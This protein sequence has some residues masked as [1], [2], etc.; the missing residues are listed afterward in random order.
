MNAKKFA[1]GVDIGGTRTKV[2]LVDLASGQIVDILINPTVTDDRGRFIASLQDAFAGIVA[3]CQENG[4]EISG[5]GVGV[6]GYVNIDSGIVDTTFGFLPFMEDF[7][8]KAIVEDRLGIACRVDNDARLNALG[9]YYWGQ[10]KGAARLLAITLGTGVGVGLIH[11]G[12]FLNKHPQEH[13][14][15]HIKISDSGATCYCGQKGC[16]E[17]RISAAALLASYREH[18]G[19]AGSA[20]ANETETVRAVFQAAEACEPVA[21]VVIGR[22]LADLITAI[23]SYI[24]VFAPDIIV[25]GGG[26]SKNLAPRLREIERRIDARP[27]SSYHNSLYISALQEEAGVL[28]A[29]ALFKSEV[30]YCE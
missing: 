15:G 19:P 2:G 9:E 29:A 6:T 13:M 1:V 5:I 10:G 18:R 25:L 23:D 3:A 21:S 28:G 22:F 17:S 14:A 4:A 16:L 8:L 26:V 11:N 30:H 27:F 20:P 7:P 24:Y 12:K